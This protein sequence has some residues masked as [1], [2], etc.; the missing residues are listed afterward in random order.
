[1]GILATVR[2][3][4]PSSGVTLVWLMFALVSATQ[5]VLEMVEEGMRY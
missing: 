5:A 3:K 4:L 1:M 2:S